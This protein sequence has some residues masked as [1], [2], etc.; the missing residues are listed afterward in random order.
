[1]DKVIRFF[2]DELSGDE[3][4]IILRNGK[5]ICVTADEGWDVEAQSQAHHDAYIL[6][7]ERGYL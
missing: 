1:M 6:S 2:T 4:A 3:C 7:L 5:E